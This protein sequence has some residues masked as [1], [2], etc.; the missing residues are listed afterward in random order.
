MPVSDF[1][2]ITVPVIG[3]TLTNISYVTGDWNRRTGMQGGSGK[4]LNAGIQYGQAS[5]N[6]FSMGIYNSTSIN[7]SLQQLSGGRTAANDWGLDLGANGGASQV[8]FRPGNTTITTAISTG[9]SGLMVVSR[10]AA[11]GD[12]AAK[13][14]EPNGTIR[15]IN[16]TAIATASTLNLYYGAL[17]AGGSVNLHHQN[18]YSVGYISVGTAIDTP[19]VAIL[20]NAL[21]ALDIARAD[22]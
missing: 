22:L 20:R 2:G 13:L 7:Y 11:S 19:Q 12:D 16:S 18:R 15:S 17:N 9:A 3:P 8:R 4:A 10:L 1:A 6:I 14:F 5:N 21:D